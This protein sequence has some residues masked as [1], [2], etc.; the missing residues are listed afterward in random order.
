[1]SVAMLS[2]SPAQ[3]LEVGMVQLWYLIK[4]PLLGAGLYIKRKSCGIRNRDTSRMHVS[5]KGKQGL[6]TAGPLGCAHAWITVRKPA[7]CHVFLFS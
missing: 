5:S 3:A 7:W 6:K 1:M 2:W 4:A